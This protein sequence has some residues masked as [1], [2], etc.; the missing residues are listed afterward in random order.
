MEN[1][2]EMS[3]PVARGD[4]HINFYNK[5]LLLLTKYTDKQGRTA[6]LL[7]TGEASFTAG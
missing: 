4:N 3:N 6:C 5:Y 2:C 7:N 1:R